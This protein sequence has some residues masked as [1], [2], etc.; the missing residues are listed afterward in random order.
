MIDF[1]PTAVNPDC[2]M[3][4]DCLILLTAIDPIMSAQV[5]YLVLAFCLLLIFWPRRS[6]ESQAPPLI[7]PS[8]L[9]DWVG[10]ISKVNFMFNS[11]TMLYQASRRFGNSPFRVNSDLGLMT[12]FPVDYAA[13]LRNQPALSFMRIAEVVGSTL[14][15]IFKEYL[16]TTKAELSNR[17]FMLT[18]PDLS[19]SRLAMG[20]RF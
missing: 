3:C 7:N 1:C 15:R 17:T 4:W 8:K 12:V 5:V 18:S 14:G 19:L 6:D 10:L 20:R 2:S 13:E 16:L 9:W 11:E